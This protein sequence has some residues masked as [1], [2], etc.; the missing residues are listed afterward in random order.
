MALL[1]L[2]GW[3]VD[4][5]K[6][7]FEAGDVI[8]GGTDQPTLY[9]AYNGDRL[10]VVTDYTWDSKYYTDEDA[11]EEAVDDSDSPYDIQHLPAGDY[12]VKITG[13]S[14]FTGTA[15]ASFKVN[16]APLEVKV[17]SGSNLTLPYGYTS[18]EFNTYVDGLTI[19]AADESQLK[20]GETFVSVV[21]SDLTVSFEGTTV[22]DGPYDITF[23]GLEADNYEITYTALK[24]EITAK[25]L[26]SETLDVTPYADQTY[27]GGAYEPTYTVKFGEV[28]LYQGT[29]FDV[30]TYSNSDR[31]AVAEP[32]NAAKYYVTLA[33][34]GNYSGDNKDQ[35]FTINRAQ[36][37][38]Q[39]G[40]VSK[41]YKGEDYAIDDISDDVELTYLGFLG[42]DIGSTTPAGLVAPTLAL[43]ASAKDVNDAGYAIKATGGSS[44]NYT[45]N[46]I[47]SGKL[48]IEPAEVTITADGKNKKVGGTEPELTYSYTGNKGSDGVNDIFTKEPTVSR[49]DGET[50]GHYKITASGAE[51]TDNYVLNEYVDGDFEITQGA[52]TITVLNHKKTYGDKNPDG[53]ANPVAEIDYIVTGAVNAK[54]VTVTALTKEDNEDF[55][56][57]PLNADYTYD[58]ENYSGVT[59]VP[60]TFSIEKRELTVEVFNQTLN[61]AATPTINQ[62]V[63]SAVSFDNIA[64]GE[65]ADD[66]DYEVTIDGTVCTDTEDAGL[67]EDA[68]IVTITNTNYSLPAIY[69]KG[70]LTLIDAEALVLNRPAKADF[71]NE[72]INTAAAIIEANDGVGGKTVTF[73]DF[74]MYGDKWYSLV[75]PFAT[76]VK[77]ISRAFGYAIVDIFDT[78]KK[79]PTDVY[80]KLWMG[81]IEANTPFL[82][83]VY[84]DM[85]MNTAVF[86]LDAEQEI[87]N[88]VDASNVA[89]SDTYGNQFIGTYTGKNGG[90]DTTKDYIFSMNKDAADKYAKA[91]ATFYVRPLGAYIEFKDAQAT[92]GARTIHI[93]ELDGSYTS[94]KAI[95]FNESVSAEGWYTLGGVKLQGAPTEKG[96]YIN[97]GK[98]VVIK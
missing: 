2:A 34:K 36:M 62:T 53:L 22:A 80:F 65:T 58:E 50:V 64:E 16:R 71:G 66:L 90:F 17:N 37:S 3:A 72:E 7:H 59:V 44:T 11:M 33:F 63:G 60:G 86:N 9:A 42:T 95:D 96:V 51:F 92:S 18:D 45:L 97:N 68:L 70:D 4:L 54:D 6:V 73:G 49:K 15:I 31:D 12:Y 25:N 27:K 26:T 57:Y 1:P 77:D 98:K 69:T 87:V 32:I 20:N 35:E 52:I 82:I 24:F 78:T 14:P 43:A 91:S 38:V 40:N 81:N 47:S 28:T 85:N 30:E 23:G 84:Q 56:N 41:T 21:T 19:A 89:I 67:Y 75:L 76:S 8:Y 10:T 29:D 55:G 83:K 74:E 94:I 5:S 48:T 79:D 46:I 88:P 39:V 13:V 93:E 61:A